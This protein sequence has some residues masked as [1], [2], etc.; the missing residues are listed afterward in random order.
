MDLLRL[1]EMVH[2]HR[3]HVHE[4]DDLVSR[5]EMSHE[6][7]DQHGSQATDLED[8]YRFFQDMR[9]FIHDL[10]ECLNEK[11]GG[12]VHLPM[13]LYRPLILS[14]SPPLSR[15]AL[16]LISQKLLELATSLFTTT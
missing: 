9:G 10:V 8:Q 13:L 14:R 4:R 2:V 6:N 12:G 3:V 5:G 7:I 16:F 11:V 15:N 1:S